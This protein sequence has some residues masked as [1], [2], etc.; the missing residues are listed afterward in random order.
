MSIAMQLGYDR[1]IENMKQDVIAQKESVLHAFIVE[2]TGSN[3]INPEEIE[4][5]GYFKPYPDGV[6]ELIWDG[7]PR[8][9]FLPVSIITENGKAQLVQ[10]FERLPAPETTEESTEEPHH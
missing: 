9:R 4:R 10:Q 8:I 5:R 3:I 7:N 1:A 2:E 6:E